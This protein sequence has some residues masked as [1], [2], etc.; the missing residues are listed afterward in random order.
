MK[1]KSVDAYIFA[2]K[3]TKEYMPISPENIIIDFEKALNKSLKI[4]YQSVTPWLLFTLWPNDLKEYSI[5]KLPVIY[6][7]K[8]WHRT[9]LRKC[10]ALQYFPPNQGKLVF[11]KI[12]FRSLIM[13]KMIIY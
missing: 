8:S 6:K 7:E 2:F 4:S 13:K 9:I 3:K 12:H 10:H 11:E 1:K 5:T